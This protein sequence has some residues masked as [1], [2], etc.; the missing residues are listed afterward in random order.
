M[1]ADAEAAEIVR[2]QDPDRY[3][4]DLFVPG[5]LRPDLLVLHAFNAEIGR[6]RALVSE[7][8][9]GEIRLQWWRDTLR[10]GEAGGHPLAGALLAAIGR[11]HLPADAFDRYL[12]ARIFDL[13]DDPMPDMT[14]FEAYAGATASALFQLAAIMLAGGRD[15]GSAEAAGH[16]GVAYALTGLLRSFPY[17]IRRGQIFLPEDVLGRFGAGLAELRAGTAP[18]RLPEALAAFR[19]MAREHLEKAKALSRALAPAVR[20]AF[21]PLALVGPYL[22]AMDATRGDPLNAIVELPQWRRQWALWR[23]SRRLG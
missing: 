22:S 14:A 16:A 19:A 17:N 9:P 13:Y 18:P 10:T 11:R 3:F 12:E 8:L 20:T 6:I 15:P 4:A 1:S 21:L 5:D 2:R 7:P 23:A